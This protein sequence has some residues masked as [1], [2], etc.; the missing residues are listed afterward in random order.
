MNEGFGRNLITIFGTDTYKD[1]HLY[2]LK[3]V[4]LSDNKSSITFQ[5]DGGPDIILDAEGDCCSH[6]WIEHIDV[7]PYVIGEKLQTVH[8]SLMNRSG[9]EDYDVIQSYKTTF[10]TPKGE[11]VIEY[12]NSSNGYYGGY[13]V[14]RHS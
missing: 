7:P 2:P 12:R 11:I 1:M 4:I 10:G 13:L 6:T 3:A 9:K 14:R 8:D 5:F